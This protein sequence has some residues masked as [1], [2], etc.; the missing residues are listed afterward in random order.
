M[1]IERF[2]NPN[3]NIDRREVQ[4][5]IIEDIFMDLE[6][7]NTLCFCQPSQQN[8]LASKERKTI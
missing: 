5:K 7:L 4:I 1:L 3:V 2:T 8:E 6:M